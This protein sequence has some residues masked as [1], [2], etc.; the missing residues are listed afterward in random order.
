MYI[1]ANVNLVLCVLQKVPLHATVAVPQMVLS[2]SEVDFGTCLVGQRREMQLLISNCAAAHCS[3]SAC[4][5][6][7]FAYL[8][9][10]LCVAGFFL[11]V[12]HSLFV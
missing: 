9:V 12:C 8:P 5:G 10:I 1:P 7:Y 11:S 4:F 6:Q 2:K 3:W